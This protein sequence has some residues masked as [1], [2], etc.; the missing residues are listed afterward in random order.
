MTFARAA[1]IDASDLSA[2]LRRIV[3]DVPDLARLG[4]P[5]VAD[6]AVGIYFPP[7]GQHAAA[8]MQCV[9]GVWQYHDPESAPEGRNYSVRFHDAETKHLTIDVVLHP[10]GPG[11]DW[12]RRAALGDTVGLSHARSWYRPDP[13]A[14]W[15]LLVADLAG[16]PAMARIIAESSTRTAIVA[17]IE[18][19][20]ES[21]L[22]YLPTAQNVTLVPAV[23]SGNGRLGG[24]LAELVVQQ[25]LPPGRGYCWCAG[26]AAQSRAV[27]KYLRGLGWTTEQFDVVGYWRQDSASWD[28]RFAEV[29]DEVIVVYEQALAD[30][31]GVKVASEEFDEALER[32]G[33]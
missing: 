12:A 1:V 2:R 24:K 7:A 16:M 8:E 11:T 10:G 33:L 30:G 27:R 26:E 20:D 19:C 3:L 5:M 17:I 23:G 31:K 22:T 14:E 18:V 32:I 9:A 13:T 28:R 6:A 25:A 29:A 21:D 4:L 15:Q